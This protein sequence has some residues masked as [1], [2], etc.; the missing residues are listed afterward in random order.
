[1]DRLTSRLLS[2]E[3]LTV[4]DA[5]HDLV[6]AVEGEGGAIMVIGDTDTG[7]TVLSWWLAE[8]LAERGSAAVVDADLGQSL[9][10]PPGTVGWREV[11]REGEEFVFVGVVSPAERPLGAVTATWRCVQHAREVAAWVVLDTSGYVD[12]SGA[13]ALK[14]AKMDLVSPAHVILLED[15]PGRLE[16]VARAVRPGETRL[17]RLQPTPAD[18]KSPSFRQRWRQERFLEYIQGAQVRE[19]SLRQRAVYG[20]RPWVWGGSWAQI[21]E[22]LR[23]LLIGLSD[24][25]GIGLAIGLLREVAD[26]GE[27]LHLLTPLGRRESPGQHRDSPRGLDDVAAVGLG[28]VRL[29]EDGTQI[30]EE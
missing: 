18:S 28:T 4:P 13:I 11:G 20:G 5:W 30:R 16:A 19:I 26:G 21:A 3:G 10:G 8:R 24:A 27:T 6:E 12:G 29:R 2:E 17:H 25:Q 9:L 23:G 15:E 22:R 1:M 7:K 14:R